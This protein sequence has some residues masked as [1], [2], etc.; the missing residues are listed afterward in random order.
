MFVTHWTRQCTDSQP[1]WTLLLLLLMMIMVMAGFSVRWTVSRHPYDLQL[2]KTLYCGYWR[3]SI[4][5]F[6][7]ELS[8]QSA[9]SSQPFKVN[10]RAVSISCDQHSSR[11]CYWNTWGLARR[12]A[13]SR[14]RLS[15]M[16]IKHIS[17]NH[18]TLNWYLRSWSRRT[19]EKDW[20]DRWT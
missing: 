14:M 13:A 2:N 12:T 20:T 3:M 9:Y 15:H 16:V 6:R 17:A 10:S 8:S 4:L 7:L 5:L 11:I 19:S 1:R 18:E